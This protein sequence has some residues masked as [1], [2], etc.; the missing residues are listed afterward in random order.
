MEAFLLSLKNEKVNN[1][2]P[3]FCIILVIF[4]FLVELAILGGEEQKSTF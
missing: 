2:H 1:V 3:T 4:G